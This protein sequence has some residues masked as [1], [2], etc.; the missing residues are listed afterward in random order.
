MSY[1]YLERVQLGT[2][3]FWY[4]HWQVYLFMLYCRTY[5]YSDQCLRT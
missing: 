2:S 5:V 1:S 3:N 4:T